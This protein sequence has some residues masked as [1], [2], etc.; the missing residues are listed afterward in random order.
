MA[1]TC[2]KEICQKVIDLMREGMT[3]KEVCAEIG[4]AATTLRDW[5]DKNSPRYEKDFDEAYQE[6][7]MYQEAW[8][9]RAGRANL[10]CGKDFNTPLFGLYM[11]NMF[12]WRSGASR[13][14]EA[15]QEIKKM[16]EHLGIDHS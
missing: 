1:N 2:N 10:G 15:L 5:K 6:G 13:D 9:L 8:W 12:G 11:A 7:K 16:K 14:D 3:L 4:I